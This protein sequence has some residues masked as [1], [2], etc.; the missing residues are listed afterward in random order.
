VDLL[1][2]LLAV[3]VLYIAYFN[4]LI[5]KRGWTGSRDRRVRMVGG[6]SLVTII[7]YPVATGLFF[8][9]AITSSTNA[10][11]LGA[12]TIASGVLIRQFLRIIR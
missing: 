10:L 3:G 6:R 9:S 7:L 5:F 11:V 4:Y 1:A 8:V 12:L 2:A